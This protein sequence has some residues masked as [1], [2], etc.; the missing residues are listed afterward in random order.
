MKRTSIEKYQQVFD[1]YD[2]CRSPA[3]TA[4]ELGM[5]ISLIMKMIGKGSK[6]FPAIK[7]VIAKREAQMLIDDE[8]KR[9]KN[10]EM[11][12]QAIDFVST[13][14]LKSVAEQVANADVI[15]SGVR[16]SNGRIEIDEKTL[17]TLVGTAKAA[18]ELSEDGQAAIIAA[19]Q[20]VNVDVTVGVDARSTTEQVREEHE[21]FEQLHGAEVSAMGPD[22]FR[23]ILRK[24]IAQRKRVEGS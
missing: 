6:D 24:E 9:K 7:K 5:N 12:R 16:L 15:P 3:Q 10:A 11:R 2:R 22:K 14:A 4:K 21:E 19:Q 18:Y 13:S 23:E 1:V 8:R 20:N 17:R